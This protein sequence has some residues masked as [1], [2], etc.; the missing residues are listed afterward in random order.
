MAKRKTVKRKSSTRRASSKMSGASMVCKTPEMDCN[1]GGMFYV[2]GFIGAFVYYV[3]VANGFWM[4]VAG[5]FKALVWPAFLVFKLLV[6]L[7]A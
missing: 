6:M 4:G 5:F 3:S 7:G 2:L 1:S